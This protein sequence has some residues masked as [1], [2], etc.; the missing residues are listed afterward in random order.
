M[1]IA[2]SN[3]ALLN[4]FLPTSDD[5]VESNIEQINVALEPGELSIS[6]LEL[7]SGES[8]LI[9]DYNGK[10]VLINTGGAQSKSHFSQQLDIFNVSEIDQLILTDIGNDHT[11]NLEWLLQE[12][13]VKNVL[14]AESVKDTV[15]K[16]FS[17]S[18]D[19][20]TVVAEHTQL[21]VLPDLSMDVLYVEK[22]PEMNQGGLALSFQFGDNKLMY[23]GVSSV[24]AE[25]HIIEN[26]SVKS[27]ILKVGRFGNESGTT[28]R[29]LEKI[30]PQI[31]VLF[32]K[33]GSMPSQEVMERLQEGWIDI[34]Q[35]YRQGIVL[36]RCN[37]TSYEVINVPKINTN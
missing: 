32:N 26:H 8:T 22:R 18:S 13:S 6:F 7:P 5:S 21:K 34:Y 19:S 20:L 16:Q 36:L 17:I 11:G 15:M 9:Q 31:A 35:P 12:F 37:K 28:Q 33:N 25:E 29:F 1:L 24:E 23:M 4:T 10:K 3:S 14:I 27:H 30:D 2:N